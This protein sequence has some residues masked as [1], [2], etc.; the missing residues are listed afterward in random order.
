MSHPLVSPV[1]MK[2]KKLFALK[3]D[4]KIYSLFLSAKLYM[5]I[6]KFNI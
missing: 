4:T 1:N 6:S 3:S 5:R 2:M